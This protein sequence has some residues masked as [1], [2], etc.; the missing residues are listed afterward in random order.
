MTGTTGQIISF[1]R[2]VRQGGGRRWWIAL[3]LL[4]LGQ[5]T[6]GISLL[7]LLPIVGMTVGQ[8]LVLDL[9]QFQIAGWTLPDVQISLAVLLMCLVGLITLQA[10]FNRYKSVYLGTLIADFSNRVQSDLFRRI[11]DS[12]WNA[13]V[14]LRASDLDHAMTDQV[15]RVQAA[16]FALLSILQTIV[17]LVIYAGICLIVSVPM[18][19]FSLGFGILA[20]VLLYPFRR[21]A[22]LF[23][24]QII[25][26]R[27]AQYRTVAELLGALKLAKSMNLEQQYYDQMDQVL[28]K[29][30]G[31][32]VRYIRRSTLGTALLQ[33]ATAACAAGFV[34]VALAVLQVPFAELVVL[35]LVLLRVAPR[36]LNL[37]M[38]A[39]QVLTNIGAF[40]ALQQ[41]K[42]DLK[43]TATRPDPDLPAVP[44]PQ[45]SIALR[46][47]T[48]GY[49]DRPTLADITLTLPVGSITSLIGPS[50]AGKSTAADIFMGLLRPTTGHLALD[51][52]PLTDAHIKSWR[53]QIAY[54]PQDTFLFNDTV[55]FNVALGR[56]H[57]T[58]AEIWH[59]LDRA[60][61]RGFV[62]DLPKGLDT[63]I[64]DRGALLSGG[65]RQRL[66]LA[67][68]LLRNPAFLILDE[69]TSALDPQNQMII[70]A[71]IKA[72][73]GETT[74]LIIAHQISLA[75]IADQ[76]FVL[77]D[78]VV[79]RVEKPED[80]S[81]LR[82]VNL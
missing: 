35:I 78:G 21:Q 49:D 50:G 76:M 14:R 54:V 53:D 79:R 25:A 67:R 68:A 13:F 71:T 6:E 72:L 77:E 52:T 65:E 31:D 61:A 1:S 66:A 42:S 64:G 82:S 2:Y 9:G 38:Q 5:L 3:T 27:K 19:L 36:F 29:G 4:C 41:L 63:E 37:Q 17:M 73:R 48:F 58:D 59:A 60:Q 23:G 32:G 16:G 7:L 33:I 11:G 40:T 20:F 10:L 57:A 70:G 55:R 24:Q 39:Q 75:R 30:R 28:H 22:T 43:P 15:Q 45:E 44:R 81:G 69:A 12:D 34:Y 18:T 47:I 62:Q 56:P 74:V 51:D 26:N 80:G 8:A 46:D